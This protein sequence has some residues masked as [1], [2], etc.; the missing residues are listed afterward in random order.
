[1]PGSEGQRDKPREDP[2]HQKHRPAA[3]PFVYPHTQVF[4]AQMLYQRRV[5]P[6]CCLA[7]RR[8]GG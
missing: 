5:L 1:M 8:F 7:E 3:Y 2:P 4:G 6:P